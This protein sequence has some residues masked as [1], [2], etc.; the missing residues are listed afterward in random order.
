MGLYT[1]HKRCELIHELPKDNLLKLVYTKNTNFIL[2]T[3]HG[4]RLVNASPVPKG[5]IGGRQIQVLDRILGRHMYKRQPCTNMVKT[6]MQ[7]LNISVIGN[8][9]SCTLQTIWWITNTV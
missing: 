6:Q 4:A 3:V 9:H 8:Y 1:T 2:Q 7:Q 5:D